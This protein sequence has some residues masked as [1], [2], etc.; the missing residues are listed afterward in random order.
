MK[1][2]EKRR[3]EQLQ[4]AEISTT[5]LVHDGKQRT[6]HCVAVRPEANKLVSGGKLW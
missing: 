6:Y 4:D 2:K 3:D 5:R 1:K